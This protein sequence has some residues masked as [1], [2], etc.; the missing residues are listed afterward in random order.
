MAFIEFVCLQATRGGLYTQSTVQRLA[1]FELLTVAGLKV[2]GVNSETGIAAQTKCHLYV[3]WNLCN[4]KLL[5][6]SQKV[7]IFI[8]SS[9]Y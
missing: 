4:G 5:R 6:T 1:S 7:P 8:E 2:T 3:Q 9:S